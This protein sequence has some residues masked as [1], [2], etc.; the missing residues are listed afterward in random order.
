MVKHSEIIKEEINKFKK[1]QNVFLGKKYIPDII[2]VDL[3]DYF[4]FILKEGSVLEQRTILGC[5]KN[6]IIMNKKSITMITTKS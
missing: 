2:N 1:L 5:L 3:Q 4:K 6:K